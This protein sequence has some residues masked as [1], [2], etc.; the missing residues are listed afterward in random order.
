[1]EV[2]SILQYLKRMISFVVPHDLIKGQIG[3]TYMQI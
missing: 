2:V 3:N 1:M